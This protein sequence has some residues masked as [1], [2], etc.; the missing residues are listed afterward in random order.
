MDFKLQLAGVHNVKAARQQLSEHGN[1]VCK[2]KEA[3]PWLCKGDGRHI[4]DESSL[5][6][7][8]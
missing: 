7:C 5:A 3:E 2:L 8:A 1:D 6:L 4:N